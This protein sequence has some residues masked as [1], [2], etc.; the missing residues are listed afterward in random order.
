MNI[1]GVGDTQALLDGD[2]TR[3]EKALKELEATEWKW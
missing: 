1:S 3:V 2:K